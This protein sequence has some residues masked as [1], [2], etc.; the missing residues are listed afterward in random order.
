MLKGSKGVEPGPP[1]CD[2]RGQVQ[3]D[4]A[5]ILRGRLAWIHD[6]VSDPTVG[7]TFETLPGASLNVGG[8]IPAKNAALLSGGGER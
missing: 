2:P 6:W 3:S 7:A 4:A 1:I 8:T 5:L